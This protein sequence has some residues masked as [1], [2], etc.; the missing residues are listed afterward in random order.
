MRNGLPN[1]HR[2]CS[3]ATSKI[4][5]LRGMT[6]RSQNAPLILGVFCLFTR[7][8]TVTSCVLIPLPSTASFGD[9]VT[10]MNLYVLPSFSRM[11]VAFHD[12]QA[13]GFVAQYPTCIANFVVNAVIDLT[14][15]HG[16]DSTNPPTYQPRLPLSSGHMIQFRAQ[17]KDDMDMTIVLTIR[18]VITLR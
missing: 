10:S 13:S 5:L 15:G 11:S 18:W 3:Y 2:F 17:S 4:R 6:E 7:L 16:Y 12:F 9:F 8:K 1:L 14:T